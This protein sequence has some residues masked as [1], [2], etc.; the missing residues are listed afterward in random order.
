M[1]IAHISDTHIALTTPDAD[2]RMSDLAL[3][4]ADINV[5][6]PVPDLII[7]T[8]DITHSGQYDEYVLTASVLATARVPV[9]V[10]AGNKDNRVNLRKAL[11]AYLGPVSDSGYI[12]Y[13]I[14]NHSVR[15]IALDTFSPGSNKGDFCRERDRRLS[16][17]IDA[18]SVKP[19]AVFMHHP[20]F[21]V[22][23]GPDPL[24]FVSVDAM[25]RVQQALQHSGRVSAI[26]SGHVH[27]STGGQVGCIPA[28]VVPS[29]ATT[30]RK[31]EYP[32]HMKAQPVY[33]L[34]RF[35]PAWGFVTEARIVGAVS[36]TGDIRE[37]APS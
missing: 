31:G 34:H 24:S 6:D 35:D 30:L 23:V 26:F 27:R 29:T 1:I 21:M 13:A 20:P 12:D 18:E 37:G 3:T 11:C 36:S 5:L 19:I 33:H 32:G 16:E 4:I 15:L 10:A 14:D 22:T 9:Y 17:L 7:H 8:G 25:S 2:Q 28:T